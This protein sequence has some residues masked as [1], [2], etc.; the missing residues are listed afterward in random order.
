MRFSRNKT[1]YILIFISFILFIIIA[2]EFYLRK[3]HSNNQIFN[4]YKK[5]EDERIYIN[6]TNCYAKEKYFEKKNETIYSTNNIGNR[7][8]EKNK[9]IKSEKIH[10]KIL[11]FGD[12]FTFGHLSNYEFTYPYNTINYLNKNQNENLYEEL[13][14]GT[15]GYQFRQVLSSILKN[16]AAVKESKF[17]IYG[18]PANDLY[19][20]EEKINLNNLYKKDESLI[21]NLRYKL[22]NLNILSIKIITAKILSNDSIYLYLHNNRGTLAGYLNKNSTDFWD[23]KYLI[24]E[25]EIKKIPDFIKQKL[26]ISIIPQQPQIMLIKYKKIDDGIAF[27]MRILEICRRQRIICISNTVDLAKNLNFKTHYK[28]DGHMLEEANKQYGILLGREILKI[29]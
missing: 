12:S 13:N 11:F 26:I 7:T 27:D 23:K 28:L 14:F 20:L 16:E 25:N 4:C 3:I 6:N 24:F 22:N 15:N 5:I 8:N 17:I 9:K 21:D 19:D 18:L 29:K 10:K 1:V 2:P